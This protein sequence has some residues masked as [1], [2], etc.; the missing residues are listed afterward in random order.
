M[1]TNYLEMATAI[2]RAAANR[3]LGEPKSALTARP[4]HNPALCVVCQND[5]HLTDDDTCGSMCCREIWFSEF[6]ERR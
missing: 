3:V 6:W 2:T 1:T 4:E 5:P